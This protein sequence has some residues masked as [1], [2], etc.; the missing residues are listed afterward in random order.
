[1]TRIAI[2]SEHASPLALAGG[3]DAGGQNIYVAHLAKQLAKRGY[4]IDVFTRRD[5]PAQPSVMRWQP[6]VR[7]VHLDAGPAEYLPKEEL[8]EHMPEFSDNLLGFCRRQSVPY[9]L[10]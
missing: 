6:G 10:A 1:M 8:L 7:V 3:T 5:D 2:I 9:A 4:R